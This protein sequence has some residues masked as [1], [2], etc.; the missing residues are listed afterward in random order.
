MPLGGAESVEDVL[1]VHSDGSVDD[2]GERTL[3]KEGEA[4]MDLEVVG[5]TFA[6]TVV[7]T[8]SYVPGWMGGRGCVHSGER[9]TGGSVS[10]T[11]AEAVGLLAAMRRLRGHWKGKV[12]HRLDNW[13]VVQRYKRLHNDKEV[14]WWQDGDRDIWREIWREWRAWG[15]RYTVI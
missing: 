3:M 12:E 4:V 14:R 15:D 11:R 5:A 13:G 7:G 10:S 1:M 8:H 6:W 2:K 9:G